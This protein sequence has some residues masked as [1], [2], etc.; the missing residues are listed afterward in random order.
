MLQILLSL[1]KDSITSTGGKG[2]N[3]QRVKIILVSMTP[4]GWSYVKSSA[5]SMEFL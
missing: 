4:A 2:P 5:I 3:C 1:Q